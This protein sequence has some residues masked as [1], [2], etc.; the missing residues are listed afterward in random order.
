MQTQASSV[1][2]R[3]FSSFRAGTCV[4]KAHH[5]SWRGICFLLVTCL[6]L[7]G[8]AWA[9]EGN[10]ATSDPIQ[11]GSSTALTGPAEGLGKGVSVGI[12]AALDEV[13]LRGGIQGRPVH[14]T[15]L[16]DGYEPAKTGPN[17]RRLIQQDKVVA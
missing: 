17:V 11:L 12:Q 5:P 9:I 4:D 1:A 14:V 3:F 13:N 7:V 2:A 6:L 15:V 16:D 10:S 8:R